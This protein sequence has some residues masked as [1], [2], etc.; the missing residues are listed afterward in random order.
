MTQPVGEAMPAPLG[1]LGKLV[2]CGASVTTT[3][4][5]R[6][7][8]NRVLIPVEE[9]NQREIHAAVNLNLSRLFPDDVDLPVRYDPPVHEPRKRPEPKFFY[10][11]DGK[12]HSRVSY[13]RK[14]YKTH[15]RV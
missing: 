12:S 14:T 1:Q 3:F 8:T 13:V 11:G 5:T 9:L 10:S 6:M 7:I 2:P 15:S 4:L